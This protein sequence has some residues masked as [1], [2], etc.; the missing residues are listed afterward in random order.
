MSASRLTSALAP[1]PTP[2]TE[3]R[4]PVASASRSP[5]RLGAPTSSRITSKG[6]CSLEAVL[7]DG[8]HA[9]A[10]SASTAARFGLVAHGGDDRGAG[11]RAEQHR[12]GAHAAGGAVHEEPLAHGQARTA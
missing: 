6:P 8:R 2:M 3:M 5:G 1:A 4:P 12:G 11:E 7:R 9:R 10:P